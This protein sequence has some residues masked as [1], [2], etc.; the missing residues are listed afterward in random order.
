MK[1]SVKTFAATLLASVIAFGAVSVAN[2]MSPR[3]Q[4]AFGKAQ[5]SAAQALSA[6]QNKIG[7]EAKVKEIEFN[8]VSYGKDYFRVEMFA[9]GQKHKVNVDATNGEILGVESKM[10]KKVKVSPNADAVPK[11]TF[12]QAMETAVAKTGGKVTEADFNVKNGTTFYKVETLNNGQE[13]IVAVDAD[14]GQIIDMPRKAKKD[15]RHNHHEKY[16]RHEKHERHE[17]SQNEGGFRPN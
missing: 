3:E 10:P 9:G 11:V 7:T 16:D 4:E 8:H 2:A 1:K 13:F 14:N 15:K 6:A 12:S 5:I 17:R